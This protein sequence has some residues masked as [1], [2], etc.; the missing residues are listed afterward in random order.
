MIFLQEMVPTSRRKNRVS[1][2]IGAQIRLCRCLQNID[3][4][5]STTRGYV[6]RVYEYIR[7]FVSNDEDAHNTGEHNYYT[8]LH[9][10][11]VVT[12]NVQFK[13]DRF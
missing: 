6:E 9:N 3:E 10:H 7:N 11:G 8:A 1:G 5:D 13:N 2:E 12:F 4:T